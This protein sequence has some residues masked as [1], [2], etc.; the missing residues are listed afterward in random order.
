MFSAV[1]MAEEKDPVIEK[2][3][4][5]MQKRQEGLKEGFSVQ[6]NDDEYFFFP[7]YID[8]YVFIS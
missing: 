3:V 7:A 6:H 8:R 4:L 5:W 1:I 2:A